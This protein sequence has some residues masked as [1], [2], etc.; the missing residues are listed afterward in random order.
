[1]A[2]A[3]DT[4]DADVSQ[5]VDFKA[6]ISEIDTK[7][8]IKI[9]NI[10]SS[11]REKLHIWAKS[12]GYIHVGYVDKKYQTQELTQ[13]KCG[14]CNEWRREH[15]TRTQYCCRNEDGSQAC[16]EFTI[17]CKYDHGSDNEEEPI[18]NEDPKDSGYKAKSFTLNNSILIIKDNNIKDQDNRKL[19]KQC[20]LSYKAAHRS[21]TRSNK[22]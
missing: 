22:K 12:K 15:E 21:M 7:G 13:Y 10:A 17:F 6:I 14:K 8:F 9:A 16:K 18:W 1:M 4:K 3:A 19:Y 5:V 11:E 2:A 20:G